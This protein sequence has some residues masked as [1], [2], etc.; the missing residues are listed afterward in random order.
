MRHV[1]TMVLLLLLLSFCCASAL[2]CLPSFDAVDQVLFFSLGEVSTRV[3]FAA[4]T[5][6]YIFVTPVST[7][8]VRSALGGS[9]DLAMRIDLF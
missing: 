6:A 4:W 7:S 1:V 5:G 2:A 9:L 3:T 8:R